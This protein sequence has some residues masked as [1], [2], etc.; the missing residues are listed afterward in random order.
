MDTSNT[1]KA[2]GII[3]SLVKNYTVRNR[4]FNSS[5][6]HTL[7]TLSKTLYNK[8]PYNLDSRLT[9]IRHIMPEGSLR[10]SPTA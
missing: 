1:I 4:G 9:N 3:G 6:Y 5:C 8:A 7:G 2:L 10:A